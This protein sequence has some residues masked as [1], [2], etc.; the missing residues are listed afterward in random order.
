MSAASPMADSPLRRIAASDWLQP[1]ERSP[2]REDSA[3]WIAEVLDEPHT[4]EL[5]DNLLHAVRDT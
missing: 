2:R 1:N 3:A 5:L 4:H